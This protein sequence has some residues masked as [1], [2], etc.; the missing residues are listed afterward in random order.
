MN[1]WALFGDKEFATN[2][3]LWR[4]QL[5]KILAISSAVLRA[6]A[7]DDPDDGPYPLPGVGDLLG[8]PHPGLIGDET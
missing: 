6:A 2:D 5:G 1:H 8:K 7:L 4:Y 3:R